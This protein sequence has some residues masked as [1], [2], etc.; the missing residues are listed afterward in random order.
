MTILIL[1]VTDDLHA[2]VV[3]RHVRAAGH[4]EC[5][6]VECDRIA[7]R[8]FLSYGVN[9]PL[10]DRVLTSEGCRISISDATLGWLRR[11]RS[12][13]VIDRVVDDE[14]NVVINNDCRGGLSGLLAAH[15][16][17]KW[18]STPEA[19]YLAGDKIGQLEVARAC[20]FRV[21]RTLVSQ[22]RSD[23]R[24]FFDACDG[25][26]I[27]KT[28]VGAPGPFLQA[29]R[30]SDPDSMDAESYAAAPAIFQECI[31][32]EDHLR[33]NCFGSRSY[34]ALI[35][36]DE[37]DW[38]ASL[39]K[40][41]SSYDVS[42]SLH[43]KVRSVLDALG[44]EMGVVDLKLTPDDEPVWLEVNPQGQFL[45]LDAY[46]DLRLGERFAEY[47]VEERALL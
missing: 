44:L 31:P 20:G 11:A 28:V 22:S 32:G 26:I 23:V 39:G 7:Q 47:L 36:S 5:H 46:T 14:A 15:F 18:I 38:R 13:Q 17:G 35:R 3:Q 45:F 21:P 37:L 27:V 9:Y 4:P 33:L 40:S 34:A 25:E 41:I 19:T 1:T 29:V 16:R 2:I 12:T 30:I 8:D 24:E 6:I 10:G 43:R 42:P